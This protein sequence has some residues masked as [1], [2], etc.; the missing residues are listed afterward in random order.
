VGSASHH[1]HAAGTAPANFNVFLKEFPTGNFTCAAAAP[2]NFPAE[3]AV[4]RRLHRPS[5]IM[6]PSSSSTQVPDSDNHL[7]ASNPA[8]VPLADLSDAHGANAATADHPSAA[9]P[10]PTITNDNTSGIPSHHHVA[11][12]GQSTA[13]PTGSTAL[14]GIKVNLRAALRQYP[15]FPSPGILFEDIMPIFSQPKLF[16]QLIEALEL[17]V[18]SSFGKGQAAGIDIVVGLE[19]RGFLFGPTLAM[20]LGAG[21]VP[22]RKQGKLPGECETAGYTKE[23]GQDFFQMQKGSIQ[24]GQRV[25]IVDDIIA[26]GT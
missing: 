20:R 11:A 26:T 14:A 13:A 4:Y 8:G 10:D 23:Y 6:A 3:I 19:S 18:A 15:D 21:F 22:V 5:S 7:S 1:A 12:G 9:K 2:Y 24:S 17:Q 16:A 25:L